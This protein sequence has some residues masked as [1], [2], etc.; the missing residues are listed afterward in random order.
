M[1][2]GAVREKHGHTLSGT[3]KLGIFGTAN[4]TGQR[5]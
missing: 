4:V 1:S 5:A 3:P 2:R